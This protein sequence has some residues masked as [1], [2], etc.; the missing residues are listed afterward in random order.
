VQQHPGHGDVAL[1]GASDHLYSQFEMLGKC[2]EIILDPTGSIYYTSCLID[3]TNAN[4]FSDTSTENW[5]VD[6]IKPF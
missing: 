5:M 2:I 1:L 4:H 6:D 3:D